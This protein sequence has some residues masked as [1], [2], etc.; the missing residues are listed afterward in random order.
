MT[1]LPPELLSLTNQSAPSLRAFFAQLGFE[2]RQQVFYTTQTLDWPANAAADLRGRAFELLAD[3]DDGAFQVVLLPPKNDVSGLSLALQRRFYGTLYDRAAEG[4]LV[5]PNK[6]WDLFELVLLIDTRSAQQ[7]DANEPLTF[8]SFSFDPR[9]LRPHQQR[10]LELLDVHGVGGLEAGEHLRRAFGRARQET[11][12]QS[13]RFFSGY[14]LEQKLEN[15]GELGARWRDLDR[16]APAVRAAADGFNARALLAALGWELLSSSMGGGLSVLRADGHDAALLAVLPP[17]APLE[18]AV[19]ENDQ[20]QLALIAALERVKDEKR[21]DMQWGVLTNGRV[22]RLYST[23]TSS[24]SGVYY[25]VDLGDLLAFGDHKDVRYLV[26][27]FG[28]AGLATDF[29][30]KVFYASQTLSK[31]VG[32]DLKKTIFEQVFR[33]LANGIAYDLW[34][35]GEYT[36]DAAQRALIFRATLVLLYRILFLLYAESSRLLPTMH[37]A[38]YGHSLTRLLTDIAIRPFIEEHHRRPL[39]PDAGWAWTWLQDLCMAIDSGQPAWGVPKYNGGLF[40]DG[41]RAHERTDWNAPHRLLARVQIG[42]LFLTKAL[43]MLGRDREARNANTA[44]TARRL[45]DYA[46]LDVRRL[47]SIYEGLLEYQLEPRTSLTPGPSP[48][49]NGESPLSP[50]RA[51]GL[52]D[53][54]PRVHAPGAQTETSGES[55]PPELVPTP[56]HG[57]RK[58]SGSYYTPDYIVAYIVEQA[59]GPVL[60]EREQRFADL[61]NQLRARR[62]ELRREE[63]KISDPRYDM[64]VYRGMQAAITQLEHDASETLLDL[65]VLD[66]AMGSGHFLVEA[67]DFLSDRL[68]RILRAFSDNPIR[69]RLDAI[70]ADIRASLH[71]QGVNEFISEGQLDD[72]S[73][74]RRLVMKRCVYGVD[75]NDMA[76]ELARLSLWLHSFTVGAPLSFLDHHLKWGNSL[77]GARAQAVQQALEGEQT[78]KGSEGSIFQGLLFSHDSAFA[79]MLNLAHIIEELVHVADANGQQVEQSRE[80]YAA[81]EEKVMPVKRLLDLWV[82]QYFGSKEAASIIKDYTGSRKDVNDLID[83]LMGRGTPNRYVQP[84]AARAR[85]L[86]QQHRFLHWDLEFPEVFIDLQRRAWKP[87]DAAG[88]DAVVGNPPYG[89][90]GDSLSGAYLAINYKALSNR[91]VFTAF[92]ELAIHLARNDG[93]QGYIVPSSWQTGNGYLPLRKFVFAN[94]FPTHAIG[95]PFNT[96]EDAFIDAG[97]YVFQKSEVKEGITAEVYDFP[98]Q[99]IQLDSLENVVLQKVLVHLWLTDAQKRILVDVNSIHLSQKLKDANFV[100]A[101]EILSSA[102]G[103]LYSKEDVSKQ[104]ENVDHQPFLETSFQRYEAIPCI[105]TWIQYGENLKEKPNSLKYFLEPRVLVRRIVS[106][107]DRLIA[108]FDDRSFVTTKDVYNFLINDN[109]YSLYLFLAIFDSKLISYL[110]LKQDTIASKDDFRQITL[111]GMRQLP[112]RRIAFTTPEAE[113]ARLVAEAT[114]MY[115][116]RVGEP[117]SQGDRETGKQGA[118]DAATW[119]AWREHWQALWDWADARLPM[120]DAETGRQ[121]DRE[122]RR[123][124]DDAKAAL[125]ISPSPNLPLSQAAEQ[126]DAVHDLLAT[127]AERMIALNKQKQAEAAQFTGWL[128]AET[129]SAIDAWALKTIVQSFWA[130]PWTEIERALQKNRNKFMQ[131]AGMRGNAADAAMEPLLRVARGRWEQS[132]AALAPILHAIRATDRLIDLIVYRLYGLTDEEIDLVEG[133]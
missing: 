98:K 2:P 105:D 34:R 100:N 9:A 94:A 47:G 69:A 133:A 16:H 60:A 1:A 40:S 36:G 126:S 93:R 78:G 86:F 82:S 43:D 10:A 66:P 20:P 128:E 45:I 92:I 116:A 27:F 107:Q 28:A 112:I 56:T 35:K 74:L 21:G 119:R 64:A 129:G 90:L 80:L 103:V 110:Y 88:F 132:R 17:D 5:L 54:S 104:K 125:P 95:L 3:L 72:I 58:A 75:L 44:D 13:T 89:I 77:I 7:R 48:T 51:G 102:R 117:G 14:Y 46:A 6:D 57:G 96:F 61:M 109:Q 26:G 23:L 63:P 38:Y 111:T 39:G 59:V 30:R 65:K 97:I 76:V 67:V 108:T 11:L 113:R 49:G 4:M 73:L 106:R 25:E 84:A 118:E 121:G 15:D 12:F 99:N 53:R 22:W 101:E 79:D 81:F 91:D 42:A 131:A 71:A 130:Q 24:I 18:Q 87:Q 85:E 124:G 37:T 19:A 70:R 62:N 114:A 31:Q 50:A 115:A 122:T 120:Q 55:Q 52:D 41:Q 32:E 83:A 33:E 127:L 8:P 29:A 68:I 123:Q